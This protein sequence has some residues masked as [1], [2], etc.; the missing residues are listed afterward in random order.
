MTETKIVRAELRTTLEGYGTKGVWFV[1]D[2]G[3][4]AM[5]TGVGFPKRLETKK[6]VSFVVEID[7]VIEEVIDVWYHEGPE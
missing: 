6:G 5:A 3:W 2:G 1:V 4:F 7:Y